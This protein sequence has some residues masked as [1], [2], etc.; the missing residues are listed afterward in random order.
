[1]PLAWFWISIAAFTC[2]TALL[3]VSGFVLARILSQIL[4]L[5]DDTRNQIQ[6]L[7]DLAASTVGHASE[8]MDIVEMRVSQ[9][10]TQA[11]LSGKAAAHHALGVGTALSGIYM[12]SRLIGTVSKM[13]K[14]KHKSAKK[15]SP[16]QIF[17][18]R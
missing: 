11:Q 14:T 3:L 8:T 10:M 1:M 2:A 17:A 4:P 7:G 5:L 12:A 15:R 6:D 13:L 9:A 16:W 18:K